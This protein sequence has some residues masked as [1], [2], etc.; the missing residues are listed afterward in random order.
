MKLIFMMNKNIN[1]LWTLFIMYTHK[2][3]EIV[4][5]KQKVNDLYF[6][7][8]LYI[9]FNSVYIYILIFYIFNFLVKFLIFQ[10][11]LFKIFFFWGLKTF[12]LHTKIIL[13]LTKY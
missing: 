7:E 9:K 13:Y 1:N 5:E 10:N 12:L 3:S 4:L 8:L 11:Y 6:I 2:N